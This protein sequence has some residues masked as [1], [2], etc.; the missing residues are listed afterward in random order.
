MPSELTQT[1]LLYIG[2][3]ILEILPPKHMQLLI[4]AVV[5]LVV[6]AI[7]LLISMTDL[8]V[9]DWLP[10]AALIAIMIGIFGC[11][12]CFG[13][14]VG[15][16]MIRK[17]IGTVTSIKAEQP[18]IE[19]IVS[20]LQSKELD[21]YARNEAKEKVKK[22]VERKDKYLKS[23]IERQVELFPEEAAEMAAA[24]SEVIDRDFTWDMLAISDLH[25]DLTN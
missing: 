20:D 25:T 6:G 10:G 13:S 7:G 22:W 9:P 2:E 24:I 19:R 15:Y 4:I 12:G 3:N 5:C 14:N 1:E 11:V 17:N 23:P 18:D 8:D 21:I 16:S